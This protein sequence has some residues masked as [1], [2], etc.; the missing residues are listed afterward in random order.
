[1]RLV[2]LILINV[3]LTLVV[4]V[5]PA[6]IDIAVARQLSRADQGNSLEHQSDGCSRSSCEL[7]REWTMLQPDHATL[8]SR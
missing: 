7:G 1:M 4:T 5:R 3:A 6:D 2:R 8:R